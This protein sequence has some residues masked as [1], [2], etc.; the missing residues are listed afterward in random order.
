MTAAPDA[1]RHPLTG[2]QHA[3]GP[4][5]P[6]PACDAHL[7]IFDPAFATAPATTGPVLPGA[8]AAHYQAVQQRL[9]TQR[10]VV[11]TPRP[12]GTDNRVTLDAIARLGAARTRGVAVLHP[13]VSDAELATL[14]AGGIRGV[15]FTLYTATQAA[16][17][18]DQ[19]APLAARV[20]PPLGWHL[21]LHWTPAQLLEHAALLQQLQASRVTLVFDHLARLGTLGPH[22]PAFAL[23]A[24]LVDAGRAWVKLSGAYLD[25]RA[26]GWTDVDTT[27]RAWARLA[28]E[29]VVWGSD[30]PHVTEQPHPP[31]TAALLHLALQRWLDTDR[32][33]QQVLVHN[34]AALYD[35]APEPEE[36]PR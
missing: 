34:P 7:H 4:V 27:A 33:R 11:V 12:W 19:V 36:T 13:E 29:R 16:T 15:R 3:A 1:G 17:R 18:F 5:P 9:G 24:R 28:P 32:Q 25:G 21:Q 14:H 31:D 22:H 30:W 10:A 6:G 35:F 8:T 2:L 26:P 20:A 23:V